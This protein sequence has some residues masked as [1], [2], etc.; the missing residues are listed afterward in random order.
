M[1]EET[2]LKL[3]EGIERTEKQTEQEVVDIKERLWN[4]VKKAM[5]EYI[6][7]AHDDIIVYTPGEWETERYTIEDKQKVDFFL[8]NRGFIDLR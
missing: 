4:N 2:K 6:Q 8:E 3:N 7:Y 5:W 1:L